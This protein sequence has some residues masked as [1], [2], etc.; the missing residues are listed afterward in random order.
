MGPSAG[1]VIALLLLTGCP[2]VLVGQAD[3]LESNNF[4][5]ASM[6]PWLASGSDAGFYQNGDIVGNMSASETNAT[7]AT[8][9]SYCMWEGRGGD[10]LGLADP[11]PLATRSY[12][13]LTI[14][15]TYKCRNGSG[16]RKLNTEYAADGVTWQSLGFVTTDGSKSYTIDAN[17]YTFAD[18]AKFRFRFTDSGGSAGPFFVDDVVIT[19]NPH[20]VAGLL[21]M[22]R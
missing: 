20:W 16:T 21:F 8:S 5:N 6:G 17:S 1:R 7:Y 18:L 11:L 19:A 13:N 12:T 3:V 14:S 4:E 9:G 2:C 22:V 10:V 15:F